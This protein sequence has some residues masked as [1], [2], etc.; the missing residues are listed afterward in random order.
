M[1]SH[2]KDVATLFPTARVIV[3]ENGRTTGPTL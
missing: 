1:V 3:I 2:D